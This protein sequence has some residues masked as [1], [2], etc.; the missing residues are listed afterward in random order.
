MVAVFNDLAYRIDRGPLT[1]LNGSE[2]IFGQLCGPVDRARGTGRGR[3]TLAG[4]W[5]LC[6][7]L[8]LG[9]CLS[10]CDAPFGTWIRALTVSRSRPGAIRTPTPAASVES[11]RSGALASEG[12]RPSAI[13]SLL[14]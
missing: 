13:A 9:C 10:H 14:W 8:A 12:L 11:A 3:R 6:R 7:R 1:L 5:G 2:Y 4:R